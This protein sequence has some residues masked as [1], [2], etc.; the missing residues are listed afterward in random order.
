MTLY[1]PQI[2]IFAVNNF[3]QVLSAYLLQQI[4]K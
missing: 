4:L 1:I 3:I 2:W